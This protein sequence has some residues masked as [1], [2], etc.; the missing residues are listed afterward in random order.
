MRWT[1][2][3]IVLK[4]TERTLW[5]TD[6]FHKQNV[7]SICTCYKNGVSQWLSCIFSWLWIYLY[8]QKFPLFC[9]LKVLCDLL[10][11]FASFALKQ[12]K[13]INTFVPNV[14]HFLL[15]RVQSAI[16]WQKSVVSKYWQSK[17]YRFVSLLLMRWRKCVE[18][19]S[20]VV[21]KSLQTRQNAVSTIR[22]N[23]KSQVENFSQTKIAAISSHSA[24]GSSR[25][26]DIILI[27]KEYMVMT[28]QS[29]FVLVM[30]K[31]D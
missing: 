15:G 25:T 1:W 4:D 10:D 28:S 19:Q 31:Q 17:S 6:T 12:N 5:W 22:L 9:R 11:I 30:S 18:K 29:R 8:S 23:K 2:I 14:E 27:A 26:W 3:L 13:N 21:E 20:L 24:L 16:T 7:I